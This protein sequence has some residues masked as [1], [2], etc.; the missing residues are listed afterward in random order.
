MLIPE[1]TLCFYLLC[2]CGFHIHARKNTQYTEWT[3]TVFMI[4]NLFHLK[5]YCKH[6][7][8]CFIYIKV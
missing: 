3:L 6:L 7:Q 4:S 8:F 2:V 5:L 1:V